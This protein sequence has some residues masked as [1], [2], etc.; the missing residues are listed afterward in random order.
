LAVI[1]DQRLSD[2]SRAAGAVPSEVSRLKLSP[3]P[4]LIFEVE[5]GERSGDGQRARRCEVRLVGSIPGRRSEAP[6]GGGESAASG[7]LS[8][9]LLIRALSPPRMLEF[10]RAVTK[11][12]ASVPTELL[13]ELLPDANTR[14]DGFRPDEL[15]GRELAVLRMLADG[16]ATREI[17]ERLSYSERT[18]KNVVHDLLEKLGCRTRAHA[19]AM[20]TRYG[21]I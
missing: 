19:V 12:G 5:A 2:S 16:L 18:V 15:T 13:A 7:E 4:T 17:A 10:V 3:S 9:V 11:G 8:V 21:V 1:A 20:A 14:P 6:D